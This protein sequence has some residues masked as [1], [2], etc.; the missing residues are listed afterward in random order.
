MLNSLR[1]ATN[2]FL[3]KTILFLI[4][5]A[6]VLYGVGDMIRGRNEFVV[7]KFKN[8]ENITLSDFN[9]AKGEAIRQIQQS[10]NQEV[11]QEFLEQI[12]LDNQVIGGLIRQRIASAWVESSDLVVGDK[13]V[14]EYIKNVPRF[15]DENGKFAIAKFKDFISKLSITE[16]EFYNDLKKTIAQN[17]LER[18]TIDSIYMPKMFE[19]MIVDFLSEER[20]AEIIQVKLDERGNIDEIVPAENDLKK[21]FEENI[22]AFKT[23]EA[24]KV[25]FFSIDKSQFTAKI[26]DKEQAEK[27]YLDEITKLEDSVAAGDTLDEIATKYKVKVKSYSGS[28]ADFEKNYDLAKFADQIFAM[29][30]KEV[31]YPTDVNTNI[32]LF[33]IDSIMESA[34]PE[35]E[36]VKKHVSDLY[37]KRRY[38]EANIAKLKAFE[39][40]AKNGNFTELLREFGYKTS[41]FKLSR[42]TRDSKLP[43]DIVANV[44]NIDLGKVSNLVLLDDYGYIVKVN[45]SS[46]DKKQKD[47]IEASQ[48]AS[49]HNRLKTSFIDSIMQYFYDRNIPDVKMEILGA[50]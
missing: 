29:S 17:L 34:I 33:E 9:K 42:S 3:V 24:R 46:V 28:L 8:L 20:V 22:E 4:A 25:K 5:A 16:D 23:A 30:E 6:L 32:I 48:I 43:D 41:T 37:L 1:N 14:V 18:V 38:V 39:S 2:S 49:I 12:N 21:Y 7:V 13:I 40:K 47:I 11:T 19:N 26:M 36:S 10:M 44:F 50:D 45:K 31:S 15:H 27:L 35:F